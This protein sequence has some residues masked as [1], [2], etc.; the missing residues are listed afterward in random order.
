MVE[1][2][3]IGVTGGDGCGGSGCSSS[4]V[5]EM[6]GWNAFSPGVVVVLLG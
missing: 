2:Y 4:V 3:C 5:V 6:I 1:W